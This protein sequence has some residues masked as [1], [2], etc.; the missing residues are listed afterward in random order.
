MAE[1]GNVLFVKQ[2]C[3]DKIGKML[4]RKPRSWRL[5]FSGQ[6]G[7]TTMHLRERGAGPLEFWL[8]NEK[9]GVGIW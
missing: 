9:A 5:L 4:P 7:A 1:N 8:G 6:P 3:E 2:K